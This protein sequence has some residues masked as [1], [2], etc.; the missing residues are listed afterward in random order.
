ML[1]NMNSGEE[2]AHSPTKEKPNVGK[3]TPSKTTHQ[4]K[5]TKKTHN[6]LLLNN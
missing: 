4:E 5:K 2:V 6:N 3:N 1:T